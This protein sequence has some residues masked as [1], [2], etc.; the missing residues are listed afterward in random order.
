MTQHQAIVWRY[1]QGNASAESTKPINIKLLHPSNNTRHPLPLGILVP[2]SAEPGLLV[3]MPTNGRITYWESISSAASADASRQRQQSVQGVVPGL[4]SGES[5]INITEAEPRGFVLIMDT[6]RLAHLVVSDPQ[7]KPSINVQFIRDNSASNGGLF[8][9]LRN[10][11]AGAGWKR[12]VAAVRAGSSY[13]RGQRYV[14][15][16]TRKGSF[17]TWELNWNGT[18]VLVNDVEAKGHIVQ[19]LTEADVAIHDHQEHRFEVH[20]F[21]ILPISDSGK[22]VAKAKQ[23]GDCKIMVLTSLDGKESSK[24]ALTELTLTNGSVAVDVVHPI[25]CYKSSVPLEDG[26]RPQILV[27]EASQTAFVVFERAL[28]LVSLAELDETPNSQLQMEAHT[29]P[30]PFEDAIGFRQTKPYRVV[31]CASEPHD[32]NHAQSSCVVMIYGFGLIRVSSLPLKKGQSA[33]ERAAVTAKTK[34]E[35]AVFFGNLQQ[36]LIDFTP[37]PEVDFLP[38][39]VEAAALSVSQSIMS[40]TSKFIP[41][42]GPSMDQQLQRRSAALADLNK[43]LKKYYHDGMSRLTKW[44]LLWNAEKMASARAIWRCYSTAITNQQKGSDNRNLLTE[45]VEAMSENVKTE[46]QP[47]HHETDGVRHWF[48]HDVWRLEHI[49]PWAQNMVELLFQEG[50][51]D[52]RQFDLA[53][54][55]RFVDE[56]N[57]IQLAGLETAFKFREENLAIYGLKNETMVDGVLQRGYDELPEFWTSTANIVERVKTLTDISR[58]LTSLCENAEDIEDGPSPELIVKLAADNPR[59]V[60]ICCQTYI[61]RFRWLK[62]R[63]DPESKVAGEDLMQAHF[64][65]RKM[66]FA[67]LSDVGQPEMGIQL[68]EK[69]R[70]MEA[71]VEIIDLELDSAE[72]DELAQMYEQ[73]IHSYFTKFGTAWA[74]AY[75]KKHLN[76]GNAVTVLTNNAEF[77]SHLTRFLRSHPPYAK[78]SWINEVGT[79]RNYLASSDNLNLAEKQETNLW[80]KK[81]GLSM[82]KLSLMAATSRGQIDHKSTKHTLQRLEENMAVLAAQEKLY[83]YMKPTVRDALDAEAETDIAM[84]KYGSNCVKGKPILR[85]TLEQC[86]QKMLAMEA[87]SFEGIIDVLT[88]IDDERIYTDEEGVMGTRFFY[89][90]KVLSLSNLQASDPGHKEILEKIIWRRA[91]IQDNWEEINRTELKDDTQVEVETGATSL[92]KTLREGYRTGFW[93]KH[94]PLPPSSLTDAGTTIESLK[95][96]SYFSNMPDNALELLTRDLE[97]EA[98]LLDQ[99]IEKGR[100]EEWWKGVVEAA[101][102]AAR[103]EADEHGEENLRK[104]NAE[105]EFDRRLTKMDKE[106]FGKEGGAEIDDQGD[107]VMAS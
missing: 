51:E 24:Y 86:L 70:D 9:S 37:R 42:I 49:L 98:D 87:L 99:Y 104:R 44:E 71:L 29:L 15:V 14:V 77:K 106:V 6:G 59:Q 4:M 45:L 62:S 38:A 84:Q 101:K 43:Y 97:V 41:V 39:E 50:V 93:E 12:D 94:A 16:G 8:G 27:P 78:L 18:H 36:D 40:S 57:D 72:S 53:T 2:T 61:E 88:L 67:S 68:A 5:V 107:V 56:A 30:A 83:N 69:Y 92:F 23:N 17:Q 28:V 95:I 73:R 7:G 52:S 105:R 34:I 64:A 65:V 58:E 81:I 19:A 46:N 22:A 31:G 89:A 26:L 91:M 76:G 25:N 20:D 96:V 35:Q 13:Q 21:T 66:L 80:S 47:E 33:L 60:Q 55:A 79:E 3:V 54:Q 103:A 63:P 11:F 48:I 102:A 32:R 82:S 74:N 75:F 1:V 90:L 10:V 85:K 100:L